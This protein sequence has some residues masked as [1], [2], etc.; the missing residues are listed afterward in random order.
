M[1]RLGVFNIDGVDY[2]LDDLTL[3]EMEQIEELAGAA[4]SEINYGSA[5]GIKAFTFVLVKK[6][7]PEL[8]MEEVGQIKVAS[9]IPAEE[10]MPALP[11]DGRGAQENPNGSPLEDSGTQ[12]SA[13][14]TAG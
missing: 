2:D 8:T 13:A 3:D 1:S 10:K 11:P 9:F 5:K 14:S 4:F 7:R 12:L 6:T